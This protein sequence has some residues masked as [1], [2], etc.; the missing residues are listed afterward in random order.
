[1]ANPNR[2]AS[3]ATTGDLLQQHNEQQQ[4]CVHPF[5]HC[6]ALL[7][8]ISPVDARPLTHTREY[9]EFLKAVERLESAHRQISQWNDAN[10]MMSSVV[11]ADDSLDAEVATSFA[12]F[13]Q[14]TA[15]DDIVTR[16]FSFLDCR[17][18]VQAMMTCS[19]F[20]ELAEQHA[21]ERTRAMARG[22]QLATKMQLLRAQEQIEGI[23]GTGISDRHVPVP[24][25]LPSRR[26][27]ISQAGDPEYNGV[28]FCTGSNGNGFVFTKPRSPEQRVTTNN[29]NESS[30]S[31]S[32]RRS[33]HRSMHADVALFDS[34]AESEV[35]QPGQLLRCII[36]KRFS[37]EVRCVCVCVC[38]V[39]MELFVVCVG[40]LLSYF[41]VPLTL[42]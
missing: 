6:V 37:N 35:A 36:A 2:G 18:L 25:L 21:T 4:S 30:S 29:N 42:Y 27:L 32:D 12:S 19:R 7:Q 22:R 41:D 33:H 10:R 14:H 16:V 20:R 17:D 38:V 8:S 26:I 3:A 11:A 15:S 28:Y 31:S 40:G 5:A 13:L 9:R 39:Y 23:A 1:M 34:A 24:A